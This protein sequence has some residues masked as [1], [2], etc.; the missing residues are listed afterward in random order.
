MYNLFVGELPGGKISCGEWF[1]HQ[2]YQFIKRK[3]YAN[4]GKFS[5]LH[6]IFKSDLYS[7][8]KLQLCIFHNAI[9]LFCTAF[10]HNFHQS[11][12]DGTEGTPLA[13][14]SHCVTI[15]QWKRPEVQDKTKQKGHNESTIEREIILYQT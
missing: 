8:Y 6:D 10:D 9:S 3:T 11:L 2:N 4:T 12:F 15:K 7:I 13:R 14:V 5:L 1:I